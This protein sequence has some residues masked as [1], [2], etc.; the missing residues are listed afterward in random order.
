M[1]AC[2]NSPRKPGKQHSITNLSFNCNIRYFPT[3]II[4]HYHRLWDPLKSLKMFSP[5][6]LVRCLCS[7][8]VTVNLSFHCWTDYRLTA[9]LYILASINKHTD[10]K[11][12]MLT[13]S[14]VKMQSHTVHKG[15]LP[16]KCCRNAY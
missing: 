11:Q 13:V 5:V 15:Y 8:T 9:M 7:A 10:G 12:K 6:I 2:Q 3:I 14:L 16:L 1:A 4:S